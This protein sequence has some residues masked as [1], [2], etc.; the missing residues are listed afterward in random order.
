MSRHIAALALA[1]GAAATSAS[2]VIHVPREEVV[3]FSPRAYR[4][5]R[6]PLHGT[7]KRKA[8]NRIRNKIARQSRRRNRA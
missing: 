7:A 2:Q 4:P 6:R 1:L 8:R 5:S 3:R